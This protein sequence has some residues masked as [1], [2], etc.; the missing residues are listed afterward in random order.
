MRPL[1]ST[2]TSEKCLVSP[3]ALHPPAGARCMEFF[4][5]KALPFESVVFRLSFRLN[6]PGRRFGL[7]NGGRNT[8]THLRLDECDGCYSL[9][10]LAT[11]GT[12]IPP[13]PPQSPSVPLFHLV[14]TA[15]CHRP[16]LPIY[17]FT[18]P[19]WQWLLPRRRRYWRRPRH[20][21]LP[22]CESRVLNDEQGS[23]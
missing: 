14:I 18:R 21:S 5:S 9:T 8:L 3:L 7:Q 19:G 13:T 20:T 16:L 10:S 1:T 11:V 23:P 2:R 6:L 15:A 17:W 4:L 12:I 22:H